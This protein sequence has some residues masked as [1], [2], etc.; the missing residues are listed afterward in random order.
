MLAVSVQSWLKPELQRMFCIIQKK[1]N[2]MKMGGKV[3]MT[4]PDNEE[5]S[6]PS[7]TMSPWHVMTA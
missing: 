7:F 3:L 1:R 2:R 6:K 5:P 4:A